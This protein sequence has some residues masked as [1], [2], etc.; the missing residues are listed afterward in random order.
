MSHPTLTSM[1]GRIRECKSV[2]NLHKVTNDVHSSVS[3]LPQD[4]A[5]THAWRRLELRIRMQPSKTNF[6]ACMME[7]PSRTV[8]QLDPGRAPTS[9]QNET[10]CMGWWKAS[11][12]SPSASW[13]SYP[14]VLLRHRRTWSAK[15]Y[16]YIA[17][18]RTQM[19]GNAR[20]EQGCYHLS[21]YPSTRGIRSKRRYTPT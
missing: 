15:Q 3:K 13:H 9:R 8:K 16:R 14:C 7:D 12:N 10:A 21:A 11:I 5:V 4:C 1:I 19:L 17:L 2:R 20:D 18:L 6:P